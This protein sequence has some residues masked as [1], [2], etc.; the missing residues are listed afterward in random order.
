MRGVNFSEAFHQ[1]R[2]A[3][4]EYVLLSVLASIC[5]Q[6]I[7]VYRW[8]LL[9][10]PFVKMTGWQAWRVSSVGNLMILL[11]PLRLGEFARPYLMRKESQASM[12]SGLAAAA[13]ERV[14]D[15]LLI[16]F[17]FFVA[18]SQLPEGTHVPA[19]L[20][21]GGY[22]ALAVFGGVSILLLLAYWHEER[23]IKILRHL[24]GSVAPVFA[25]RCATLIHSFTVGLQAMSRKH[26]LG[27]IIL[28]TVLY[29]TASGLGTY[30]IG[31]ALDWSL[32][33]IAGFT[34]M[35]VLVIGV[36]IPAGPGMLGTYQGAIVLGLSIFGI[37][38]TEA[39]A[40]GVLSYSLNFL[41]IL[42]FG[43]P[44]MRSITGFAREQVS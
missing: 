10:S 27:S 35:C 41:V 6:I 14:L 13:V 18:V 40:Y 3:R 12:T 2:R 9:V 24:L 15:G 21:L 42:A 7:R 11:L 30:W 17:C 28:L 5:I 20:V 33:L 23:M 31:E 29:W 36:M 38:S 4:F 34:V 19:A 39:A 1:V 37:G 44:F 16:C 8:Q 22:A 25:E 43:L 26:V 32:P